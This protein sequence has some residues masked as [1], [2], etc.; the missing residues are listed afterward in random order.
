MNALLHSVPPTLQQATA[1]LHLCQRLLGTH[2][3]VWVRLLWGH[4]SF[5]LGPHAHKVL[6]VPSKSLFP[7]SCVSSGGS[8]VGVMGTSSRR[9][10]A[11]PRSVAPRAPAPAQ[12]PADPYLHRGL[13]NTVVSQSLW[14]LWVL[15]Q[16]RFVWALWAF[17]WVW[18]LILNAISPLLPSFWVFSF[19]LGC[20][21][22]P[23]SCSRAMQLLLQCLLSCWGC[24][25]KIHLF[26]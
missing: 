22:S 1:D 25:F 7:Q 11:T 4:C 3:Q 12:S 8:M 2:G 16:T 10:Y 9:V 5:L 15:V 21:V 20:G 13:S 23:Q 19:A 18:G 14:G 6:F 26:F 24:F 17:W